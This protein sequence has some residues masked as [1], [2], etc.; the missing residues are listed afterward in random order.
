MKFPALFAITT[1]TFG[2]AA[3]AAK[4]E[5]F[6]IRHAEKNKDGTISAKGM[7]RSQCLIKVFGRNSKYNIQH[8]MVQTPHSGSHTSQRPYNTTLP[9]ANSLGIKMDTPCDYDDPECAAD[10]ALRYRG[11]NVLIGWEHGYLR[12]VS[13][14][15]GG[16]DVP[17]YPGDRYDLIYN[18][19]SPYTE[20][21]VTSEECP[22]LDD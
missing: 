18:Q 6:L 14:A 1:A 2:F 15:L 21:E 16:Q 12:K 22:G 19:P 9:L 10:F 13:Q 3:A 7:K 17:K 20:I 5:F 8:I 11:G 4:P